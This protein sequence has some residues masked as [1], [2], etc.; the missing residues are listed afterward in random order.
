MPPPDAAHQVDALFF[1][2]HPDDAEIGA[3]GLILSL[4]AAGRTTAIIDLSEG[5]AASSGTVEIR[6]EEA[7]RARQILGVAYRENLKLPDGGIEDVYDT[8]LLAAA[9]IRRYQPT[10]VV[11]P[12]FSADPPGR[13]IRH[14]D[15]YQT[16]LIAS[17]AFNYAHLRQLPIDGEPWQAT[18]IYYYMVPRTV[19]PT[20]V[21]DFT[22]YLDT[23]LAAIRAHHSQFGHMF[24]RPESMAEIFG[25]TPFELRGRFDGWQWSGGGFAQPFWSPDPLVVADVVGLAEQQV[26]LMQRMDQ[27]RDAHRET[28]DRTATG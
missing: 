14:S 13:G 24:D 22:Q 28:A 9:A 10:I 20:F 2:P 17:N 21:V 18:A 4:H 1:A 7:E 16:G 26:T 19:A 8:R 6:Y 15:H 12:Y 23:Y 27:L 25:Q 3:G 11:A 5:E